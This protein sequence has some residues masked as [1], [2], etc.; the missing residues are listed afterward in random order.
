MPEVRGLQNIGGLPESAHLC[1]AVQP[2][3][4]GTRR[5]HRTLSRYL[6]IE[7]E[8]TEKIEL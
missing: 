4:L 7:I 3:D 1:W 2:A 5:K 6:G 8:I